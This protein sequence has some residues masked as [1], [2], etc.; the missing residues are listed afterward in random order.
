VGSFSSALTFFVNFKDK[1]L[2][3][4]G[5]AYET[6]KNSSPGMQGAPFLLRSHPEITHARPPMLDAFARSAIRLC[7]AYDV[8]VS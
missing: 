6:A 2:R 5:C 3:H 4:A 8:V 7:A 1:V